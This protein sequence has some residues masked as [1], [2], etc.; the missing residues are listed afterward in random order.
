MKLNHYVSE[1]LACVL[2]G[3]VLPA[4]F[5]QPTTNPGAHGWKPQYRP[6]VAP[7]PA[8]Q[9]EMGRIM[10]EE[11]NQF[12][13][14]MN[15]PES[16]PITNSNVVRAFVYPPSWYIRIGNIGTIETTNYSYL[17]DVGKGVGCVVRLSFLSE[18]S[19]IKAKYTWRIS[20]LDTNAALREALDILKAA[21]VDVDAINR[22]S[23]SVSVTTPISPS[24]KEFIPM[25]SVLWEKPATNVVFGDLA[26]RQIAFLKFLEP[27]KT[28]YEFQ[29]HSPKYLLRKGLET[30]DLVALLTTDPTNNP[31]E[32]VIREIEAAT[33][34]AIMRQMYIDTGASES[35]LRK[36]GLG[37]NANAQTT[38][39]GHY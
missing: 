39:N 10:I 29:I 33:N 27:T 8:Y 21:D 14:Q 20:L 12:A 19:E 34:K 3:I 2:L 11:A 32:Y 16:L 38:T 6:G 25:Y 36:V 13:R 9:K 37:T 5:A 15:L 24:G 23:E 35:F 30:P 4:A 26:G 22:D 18:W 7:T 28:I 1:L 17:I 31:P